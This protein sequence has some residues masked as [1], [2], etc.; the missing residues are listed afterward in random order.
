MFCFVYILFLLYA[1]SGKYIS[2]TLSIC[3]T[4][5]Y[6][7]IKLKFLNPVTVHKYLNVY[8]HFKFL[9]LN[10]T[11]VTTGQDLLRFKFF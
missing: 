10:F 11:G 6:S 4:Y 9:E 7:T 8:V 5:E 2:L 3:A 1:R